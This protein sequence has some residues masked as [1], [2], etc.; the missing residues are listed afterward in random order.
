MARTLAIGDSLVS[1]DE[2]ISRAV[3][4]VRSLRD[5]NVA[6]K[7]WLDRIEKQL[8]AETVLQIE[9]FESSPFRDAGGFKRLDKIFDN[10]LDEIINTINEHLYKETA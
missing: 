9:D 7:R 1:H 5:W 3:D 8:K 2:R 4:K 10:R 6:Q